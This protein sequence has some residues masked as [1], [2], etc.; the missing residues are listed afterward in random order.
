MPFLR[1]SAAVS[2]L[3][4]AAMLACAGRALAGAEVH[5]LQDVRNA[6]ITALGAPADAE[7]TLDPALRLTRCV[8]PLQA[9]ASGPRT[10]LVRCPDAPGWRVYV[11]VQAHR[12]ADVVVLAMPASPGVPITAGHLVV[13]HREVAAL[14]G[15][16]FNDPAVLI[17]R[18]PSRLLAAGSVPT[19]ADFGAIANL[20]RGDPVTLVARSGGVEV[21]MQGR[22]LGA[23]QPGGR[24][25]VEN[26]SSGR[27][28]RGRIIGDGEVEI[29]P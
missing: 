8:Q 5:P 19:E 20:R 22:A 10:A 29:L 2:P 25:A 7:T 24:I 18:I 6:A 4:L 17:G 26:A 27:I 23:A 13:Q 21:R 3:I 16:P 15:T 28:L 14:A 12:E 1:R 9:V 11:Q